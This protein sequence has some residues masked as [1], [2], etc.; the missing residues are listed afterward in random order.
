MKTKD[1]SAFLK[2]ELDAD[3]ELAAGVAFERLAG[4]IAQML[5]D[6]RNSLSMNQQELAKRTG[7]DVA[8]IQKLEDAD[9]GDMT[10][11]DLFKVADA[12]GFSVKM[13]LQRP[14]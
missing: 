2:D 13:S 14:A 11:V 12:L 9:D 4:C 5:F 1:F 8:T 7:I 6:E 10:I 3:P